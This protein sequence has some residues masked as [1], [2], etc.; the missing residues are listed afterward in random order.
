V[1]GLVGDICSGKESMAVDRT[2][3]RRRNKRSGKAR[4]RVEA[5]TSRR[6]KQAQEWRQRASEW[7]EKAQRH[8]WRGRVVKVVGLT[9][10]R[11]S[12]LETKSGEMRRQRAAS[13][14]LRLCP[15][16]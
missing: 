14:S 1:A 7:K 15:S 2:A 9:R 10:E 11:L 5:S 16:P 4:R 12:L 6:R 13:I 3:E 8:C